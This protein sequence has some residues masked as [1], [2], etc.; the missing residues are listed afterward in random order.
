ME[1]WKIQNENKKDWIMAFESFQIVNDLN[2]VFI[3]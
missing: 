3:K 2:P 1:N